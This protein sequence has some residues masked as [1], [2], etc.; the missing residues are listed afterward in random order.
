MFQV[1]SLTT[2]ECATRL[3]KILPF[4]HGFSKTNS[5]RL[6]VHVIYYCNEEIF[7]QDFLVSVQ[8]VMLSA[9][10]NIQAYPDVCDPL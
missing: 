9:S 1:K 10:S 8:T 4:K 2:L 5:I 3:R 7:F 6:F